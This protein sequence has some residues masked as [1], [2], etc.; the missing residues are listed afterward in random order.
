MESIDNQDHGVVEDRKLSILVG[1]HG[2]V[3]DENAEHEAHY[4]P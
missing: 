2:G 3:V 4:Q 1:K